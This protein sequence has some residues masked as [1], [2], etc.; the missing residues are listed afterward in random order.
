VL[1]VVAADPGVLAVDIEP[2]RPLDATL[3]CSILTAGERQRLGR[4]AA[5]LG[6][7]PNAAGPDPLLAA[8][9]SFS[10]K[11]CYWKLISAG[12]AR[13]IDFREVEVHPSPV[14]LEVRAGPLVPV[15]GRCRRWP[16]NFEFV[17]DWCLS[18][19]RLPFRPERPPPLGSRPG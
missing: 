9:A 13:L 19:A 8:T 2:A 18:S 15:D 14:G 17:D 10:A 6:A 11:E 4:L 1:V 16:V 3:L 12:A 5:V 7:G